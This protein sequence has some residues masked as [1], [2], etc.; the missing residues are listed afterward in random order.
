MKKNKTKSQ[1]EASAPGNLSIQPAS[2]DDCFVWTFARM[3]GEQAL[4]AINRGESPK[5]SLLTLSEDGDANLT[6]LKPSRINTA[7][8]LMSFARRSGESRLACGFAVSGAGH[9]LA[10]VEEAFVVFSLTNEST[11]AFAHRIERNYLG[12]ARLVKQHIDVENPLRLLSHAF[13]FVD[14]APD[15]KERRELWTVTVKNGRP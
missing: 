8:L 12:K 1:P 11:A 9:L 3:A 14:H 13:G 4:E 5:L 10:G 2:V 7:S 6:R 15:T